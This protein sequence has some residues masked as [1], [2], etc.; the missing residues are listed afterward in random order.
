MQ[1]YHSSPDRQLVSA[2]IPTH[3][4]P[5]LLACAVRSALRQTWQRI[6]VIVVVDGPDP[7]TTSQLET[8]ADSRLR[9]IYLLGSRGSAAARNAGVRAARGDWIAFLDDDDEWHPE[10]IARQMGTAATTRDWFPIITCRLIAQSPVASRALPRRVYESPQ[11][12]A[13][14]LFCRTGLFDPGGL[15]QTSTLMVP[16]DLLL[17]VPFREGLRM[18]QDWDWLIQAG[19][20]EGVR[21]VMVPKPLV[22]WRV[23]DVRDSGSRN[24]SWQTSLAW[25]REMRP[26]VSPRAFSS[27]VAVQCAWRAQRSGADLRARLDILR[28]LILE[29]RPDRRSLLH[30]L[31]FSVLPTGLRRSLRDQVSRDIDH[32]G[33]T[34]AFA[35]E[36]V[37]PSCANPQSDGSRSCQPAF[38]PAR[39]WLR[40]PRWP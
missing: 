37:A 4:R 7:A 30:F 35:R 32:S 26:L 38:T 33:L 10:K 2:V 5:A 13:D 24:A 6:E 8:L 16:R 29:G 18:H 25:I 22:T 31:L 9:T 12:V 1:Q 28:A 19:S 40:S 15:M 23:N 11:P 34:L 39:T 21:I 27:F 17:A 3:G 20:H 14:Y 36:P